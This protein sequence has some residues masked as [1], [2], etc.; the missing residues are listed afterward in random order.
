M[1]PDDRIAVRA[2]GLG[3]RYKIYS[4]SSG[5]LVE[6]LDL[7]PDGP[8]H[9]RHDELRDA[10]RDEIQEFTRHDIMEDDARVATL[11]SAP[12]VASANRGTPPVLWQLM[13][14]LFQCAE[15]PGVPGGSITDFCLGIHR[16]SAML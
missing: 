8:S 6:L 16:F 7:D 4:D 15:L 2:E 12:M 10:M 11:L 14:W 1:K 5:R 13:Q 9:R 3:K